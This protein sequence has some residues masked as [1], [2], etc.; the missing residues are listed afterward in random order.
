MDV[1]G[2]RGD[3]AGQVD[4]SRLDM[5]AG[6]ADMFSQIGT[7]EHGAPPG[8]YAELAAS[9]E[10]AEQAEGE[11]RGQVDSVVGELTELDARSEHVDARLPELRDEEHSARER[12]ARLVTLRGETERRPEL[13]ELIRRATT[14][15]EVAEAVKPLRERLAAVEAEN[16]ELRAKLGGGHGAPVPR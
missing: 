5:D 9:A 14:E 13:T 2:D 10:A 8:R 12:A 6:I 11:A 15:A 7:V 16:R 3:A 1:G 4:E